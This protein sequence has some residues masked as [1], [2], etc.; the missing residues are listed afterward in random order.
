[1]FQASK[2]ISFHYLAVKNKPRRRRQRKNK[3]SIS[4]HAQ[5]YI[6]PT[7]QSQAFCK[8]SEIFRNFKRISRITNAISNLN[9]NVGSENLVGS[10]KKHETN[11]S[12]LENNKP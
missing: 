8:K 6:H 3:L 4:S 11:H 2:N 12:N 10:K 7:P 9:H 5:E 1:M